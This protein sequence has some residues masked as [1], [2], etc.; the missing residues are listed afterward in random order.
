VAVKVVEVDLGALGV[1]LP[2][3]AVGV[4]LAQP[5]IEFTGQEPI[6][7]VPTRKQ[8]LLDDAKRALDVARARHH[9]ADKTHFTV[10]P[11]CSL[12]GLHG[13]AVVEDAL[14][15]PD[16][17]TG[18]IV[19]GCVDGLG[20]CEYT[21]LLAG[22]HTTHDAETSASGLVGPGQWVNCSVTW[23][24]L[25][26]GEVH[27]W[28]QPKIEPAW[29]ELNRAHQSMFT[30]QSIF[31]F[32]ARCQETGTSFRFATLLCFDWIG[33]R[34]GRPIW[35][36]LLHAMQTWAAERD[37]AL[38]LNWLFVAQCNPA[39][40]HPSFMQHVVRFFDATR[41]PDALRDDTCLVMANVAGRDDPGKCEE[42]GSSAVIFSSSKVSKPVTCM[43]TYCNGG[44][45]LRAGNLLG[46]FK[47]ALFRERGACVHSFQVKNPRALPG[48]AGGRRHALEHA[49]VHP[50]H[51]KADARTPD[52][53]VHAVVKWV[54]DYLD[55]SSQALCHRHP[56]V[57]LANTAQAAHGAIEL[58]LRGLKAT[59]LNRAVLVGNAPTPP[60]GENVHVDTWGA[61]EEAAVNHMVH[62]LSILDVGG[63]QPAVHS[64]SA[65]ATIKRNGS[66]AEVVAVVAA[67]H[68]AADKHVRA[69]LPAHRGQLLVITRDTDNTPWHKAM[70]SFLDR[71]E[72]PDQEY[73]ITEPLSAVFHLG[74]QNLLEAYRHA[75][76][77]ND[78]RGVVDGAFD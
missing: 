9:R 68:E 22:T 55:D 61:K 60:A 51:G 47:D 48:D 43:P 2:P 54:N 58:S 41:F 63:F 28:V 59:E 27:R 37:G 23:A 8:K 34:D 57:P 67:T 62:A 56:G 69:K 74:Y 49:T 26:N 21:Q 35:E 30:G 1:L 33:E 11:E 42:Y 70:G 78:I 53:E 17:P 77:P 12:P 25:P 50:L 3:A 6:V 46:N 10:L 66:E 13:V 24:K 20:P 15:Q 32:K 5:R 4:V 71:R 14:A 29:V 75:Q 18:T 38:R 19:I 39:P 72:Q 45:P 64:A 40:S 65:L 73:R 44:P 52:A 16:W 36:W 7:C 31:L 76:A